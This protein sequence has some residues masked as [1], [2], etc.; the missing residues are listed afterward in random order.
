MGDRG[1]ALPLPLTNSL[2]NR[3]M[4]THTVEHS[5]VHITPQ[6]DAGAHGKVVFVYVCDAAR[7]QSV[8]V[9]AVGE[10]FLSSAC[11]PIRSLVVVWALRGTSNQYSHLGHTHATMGFT[12]V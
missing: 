7:C 12:A 8:W 1:L 11:H 10:I 4:S 2:A 5:H 6:M 9:C 3:W